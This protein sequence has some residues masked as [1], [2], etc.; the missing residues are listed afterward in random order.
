[1]FTLVVFSLP[2]IIFSDVTKWLKRSS[3]PKCG[4]FDVYIY[5]WC[6]KKH[7]ILLDFWCWVRNLDSYLVHFGHCKINNFYLS[8]SYLDLHWKGFLWFFMSHFVE[9]QFMFESKPLRAVVTKRIWNYVSFQ[10]QRRT[11]IFFGFEFLTCS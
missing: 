2:T 7:C 11:K 6:F 1:M 9:E 3:I 10:I 8:K 5:W 4:I